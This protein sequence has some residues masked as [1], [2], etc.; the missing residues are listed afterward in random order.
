MTRYLVHRVF[1]SML[2]VV[3]VVTI[4]FVLTRIAGDPA[5]LLLPEQATAQD[6]AEFRQRLGLDR[7]IH[8]QYITYIASLLRGDLGTSFR[9]RQPALELV[10]ERLPATMELAGASM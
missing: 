8:E 9:Q 4:V 5:V 10:I 1:H 6:V 2:V 7:P 3:G